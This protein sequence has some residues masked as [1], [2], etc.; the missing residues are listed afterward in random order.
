MGHCKDVF[1]NSISVPE[2]CIGGFCD[3]VLTG[4][5]VKDVTR[6]VGIQKSIFR[7]TGVS[8]KGKFLYNFVASDQF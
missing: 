5:N 3:S 6:L 4:E 2:A 1:C 8:V 7:Y